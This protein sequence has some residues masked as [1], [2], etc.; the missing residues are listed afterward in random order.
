MAKPGIIKTH[1]DVAAWIYDHDATST[2]WWTEQ[3]KLN[4][5]NRECIKEMKDDISKFKGAMFWVA[6]LSAGL[7]GTLSNLIPKIIQAAQAAVG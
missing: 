1:E 5:H 3:R 4:K 6:G 7:G 2:A